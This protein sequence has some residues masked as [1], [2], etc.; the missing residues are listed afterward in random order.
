MKKIKRAIISVYNKK[1]LK[2]IL[3]VLKKFNIEIIS[4]GGT[5]KEIKRLG[6][7]CIEVSKYTKYSYFCPE[8]RQYL[9]TI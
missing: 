9:S 3:I 8:G 7:P 5:Y 6:F 2:K 4:S 1:N